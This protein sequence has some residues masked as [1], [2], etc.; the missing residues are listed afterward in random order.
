[1]NGPGGI[2]K[3]TLVQRFLAE[4]GVGIV[5]RASGDEDETSL[6]FGVLTQLFTGA[7]AYCVDPVSGA[8]TGSAA[9]GSSS[10]PW[11]QARR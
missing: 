5:L 9:A 4:S 2:G 6:E 8:R 11:R 10:I 7:R 3:T 1:M